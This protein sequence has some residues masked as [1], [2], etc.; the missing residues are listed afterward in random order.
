MKGKEIKGQ[1]FPLAAIEKMTEE[2]L[3]KTQ[4]YIC[5]DMCIRYQHYLPQYQYNFYYIQANI[6]W[7][8]LWQ[9][10]TDWTTDG[11]SLDGFYD[12]L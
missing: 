11:W 1:A 5:N 2:N 3:A 6:E 4:K 8:G 7:E 9:R 10:G 12:G